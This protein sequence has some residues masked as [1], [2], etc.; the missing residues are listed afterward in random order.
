MSSPKTVSAMVRSR[1]CTGCGACAGAFPEAIQMK[2]HPVHGRRPI[3]DPG[4]FADVDAM[5]Y[6]AGAG[7]DMPV[8]RDKVEAE[9]GPVLKTW[10]GWATD[11]EIRYSGSSGGVATAI[12]LFALQRGMVGG[13]AHIT[14]RTGDARLNQSTISR[15]REELLRAT[16]SRYAQASPAETVGDIIKSDVPIA[17]IG[18]PCDIASMHKARKINPALHSNLGPMVAIFCAGAPNLNAT[19]DLLDRL[20]VPKGARVTSLR[21]RGNGWPGMMKARW[22]NNNG[23]EQDSDSIPYSEGWGHILEKGRRWRC[24][25]CDDHTGVFA[26]IS[27]GDPWHHPPEGNKD[28]GRSLIVARTASGQALIE[29]A[30]K[31]GFLGVEIENRGVISVA[32][33]NLL[34]TNAAVWGRR[35]AFRLLGLPVPSSK[36][37]RFEIWL[38]RLS[39]KKKAQSILGT[40]KRI[41]RDRLWQPLKLGEAK[42]Q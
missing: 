38:W 41:Y 25:L 11:D 21:Y 1:L 34:E 26:D 28:P 23:S 40:F 15:Q 18:K 20:G 37:A 4:N 5:E 36:V 17:F 10:E 13:V 31:A 19:E 32:Q 16:G 27:V 3:V 35:I 9:W 30:I 12:A 29:A 6:C 39:L 2:D 22:V 14:A 8:P 33:P 42:D 24:R 7:I